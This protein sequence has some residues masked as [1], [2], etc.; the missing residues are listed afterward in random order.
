MFSALSGVP[1][2]REAKDQAFPF[3]R[4]YY[5]SH[6]KRNDKTCSSGPPFGPEAFPLRKMNVPW[7]LDETSY[8]AIQ[9]LPE[10][11]NVRTCEAL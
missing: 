8:S 11:G 2:L 5:P 10:R 7:L 9:F 3:G 4:N 6:L 1:M